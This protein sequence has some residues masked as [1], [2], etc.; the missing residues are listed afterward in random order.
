[1]AGIFGRKAKGVLNERS[2]GPKV[3]C[4]S[5][6]RT[7]TTSVGKFFG[8]H[9]Y[10]VGGWA[11]THANQWT[12]L[13]LKGDHERIFRSEEFLYHQ[14]FEDSPWGGND[15]YKILFH[16]FPDARFV[17]LE[18]DADKW[19]DSMVSH[20]NARTL[21]NTHRHCSVYHR[22][23]DFHALD[24]LPNAY[25][26]EV[27][28]LLPLNASHRDH[29]TR[30]YRSQNKEVKMFFELLGRERLFSG[31][32]EDPDVWKKMGSFFGIDVKPGYS[33]HANRS[34]K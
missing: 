17:L 21:G 1:M 33:V 7:G 32:L 5:F 20:S 19:F 13:W 8:E 15:F 16:R 30:I 29:Y 6:Q 11:V 3:F 22:E 31:Q 9:G 26:D 24:G 12:L 25:T 23:E 14:V 4:I 10:K 18:R 28:N 2:L 34:V 27:D